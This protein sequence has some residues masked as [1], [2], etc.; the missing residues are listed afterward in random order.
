MTPV[1]PDEHTQPRAGTGPGDQ[2]R[3]VA[4]GVW[5]LYALTLFSGGLTALIGVG[6]AYAMRPRAADGVRAHFD[7]QIRLFWSALI[8]TVLLSVAWLVSLLLTSL[9]IGI[10]LLFVFWG[11][12]V[13]LGVWFSVRS[14]LGA[15]ALIDHRAP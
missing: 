4:I 5:V 6:L 8:W 9:F 7:T 11:A 1:T 3:P 12:L 2:A 14:V 13:L 10:P 15:L